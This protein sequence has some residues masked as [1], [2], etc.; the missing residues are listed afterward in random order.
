MSE[1]EFVKEGGLRDAPIP[2][3]KI[4]ISAFYNVGVKSNN[5]T[6]FNFEYVGTDANNN[7]L[8]ALK[9][10]CAYGELD[11]TVAV[12]FARYVRKLFESQVVIFQENGVIESGDDMI[13]LHQNIMITALY[14]NAENDAFI[15]YMDETRTGFT[16][17][18]EKTADLYSDWAG[19][20]DSVSLVMLG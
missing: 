19:D 10:V 12:S 20:P 3:G 6:I 16:L 1:K 15:T 18:E 13:K 5:A 11:G 8:F 4:D 7:S 9:N 2:G 14:F 17:T